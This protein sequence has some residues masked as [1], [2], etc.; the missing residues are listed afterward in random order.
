MKKALRETQTLRGAK[1]ISPRRR[2]PFRGAGRPKF[3]HLMDHLYPQ[4]QFGEDRCT[5]FRV[6][7]LTDPQT[8]KQTGTITIHCAAASPARSLKCRLTELWVGRGLALTV[9]DGESTWLFK[10]WLHNVKTRKSAAENR[11][12]VSIRIAIMFGQYIII[13]IIIIISNLYSAYYKKEHRCY[14]KKI[15]SIAAP[16]AWNRLPSELKTTTFSIETFKRR[17]KTFLF[18]TAF[19]VNTSWQCNAPSFCL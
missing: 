7:V 11:S 19:I 9:G 16:R 18:N 14:S 13:I 2:P 17:L 1:K 4:I 15:P 6:I 3:I 8:H 12:H 5:Q 10:Y